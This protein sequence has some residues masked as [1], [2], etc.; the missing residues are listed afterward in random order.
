MWGDDLS[1]DERKLFYDL[2]K[3]QD[4]SYNQISSKFP[5]IRTIRELE[6]MAGQVNEAA[7]SAIDDCSIVNN[8]P[9]NEVISIIVRGVV[10]NWPMPPINSEH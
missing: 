8:I 9:R 7:E 4:D 3:A 1:I 6:N 10:E 2:V 5:R